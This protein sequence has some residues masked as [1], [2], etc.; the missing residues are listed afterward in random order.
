MLSLLKIVGSSMTLLALNC[1][2][3]LAAVP[4]PGLFSSAP[5]SRAFQ[6]WFGVGAPDQ[7]ASLCNSL[8]FHTGEVHMLFSGLCSGLLW[9]WANLERGLVSWG[10]GLSVLC[11][12]RKGLCST[13]CTPNCILSLLCLFFCASRISML[14]SRLHQILV[15]ERWKSQMCLLQ[16]LPV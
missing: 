2:G 14:G 1:R 5:Q 11:V 9:S 6:G 4:G 15:R 16:P 13:K 10:H 8:A 3:N 12:C 7:G